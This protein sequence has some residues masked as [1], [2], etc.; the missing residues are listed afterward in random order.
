MT[1][2]VRSQ[3]PLGY[4]H[5]RHV[6]FNSVQRGECDHIGGIGSLQNEIN[7]YMRDSLIYGILLARNL[8]PPTTPLVR[9]PLNARIAGRR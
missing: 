2:G 7:S 9:R 8:L 4:A 6:T 5:A 1:G 3:D